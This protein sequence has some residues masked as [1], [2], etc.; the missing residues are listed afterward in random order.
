MWIS[1]AFCLSS[2]AGI[3]ITEIVYTRRRRQFEGEIVPPEAGTPPQV[4]RAR[5][6]NADPVRRSIEAIRDARLSAMAGRPRKMPRS[7]CI[8]C[9]VCGAGPLDPCDAGL[10]S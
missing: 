5:V 9:D 2:A 1:L 7:A 3:V 6:L 10:H 8:A 4:P